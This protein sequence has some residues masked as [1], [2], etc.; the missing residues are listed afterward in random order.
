MP[1]KPDFF[2][3]HQGDDIKAVFIGLGRRRPLIVTF[4]A[5]SLNEQRTT[6]F[7]EDFLLDRGLS[8]VH[9][10]GLRN[11]WYQTREMEPVLSAINGLAAGFP[12]VITYGSSMGGHG[13]LLF[14]QRLGATA[15]ALSPLYSVDP[16]VAPFEERY[17]PDLPGIAEFCYPPDMMHGVRGHAIY[18]PRSPDRRHAELIAARSELKMIALPFS[19]HPSGAF[20]V[21]TGELSTLALQAFT[22]LPLNAAARARKR[23]ATSATYW[24]MIS[25]AARERH[26]PLL[27]IR[28]ARRAVRLRP[29]DPRC[30][31]ALKI[32]L[33][34]FRQAA[35]R[36]AAAN[37][38]DDAVANLANRKMANPDIS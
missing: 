3:L 11:H 33:A 20:L 26:R 31:E 34:E 17:H 1:F 6:G 27:A 36:E 16:V 2:T 19:G 22:G 15:L 12:G 28:A 32:A 30:K 25:S 4:Q 37:R 10:I 5:R 35:A 13:A 7:G 14:A 18:D 8:A 24:R 29:K 21:E 38:A 9:I 23:R